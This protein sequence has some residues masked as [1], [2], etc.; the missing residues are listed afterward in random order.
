MSDRKNEMDRQQREVRRC[1][2]EIVLVAVA[3]AA[4]AVVAYITR[5]VSP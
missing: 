5:S 4:I 3:A 1:Y 2:M